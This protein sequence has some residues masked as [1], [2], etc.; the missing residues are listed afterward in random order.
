MNYKKVLEAYL[1]TKF[2]VLDMSSII[3][4]NLKVEI[5]QPKLKTLKSGWRVING[6]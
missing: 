6:H 3:P 5:I 1:R 2:L 4:V